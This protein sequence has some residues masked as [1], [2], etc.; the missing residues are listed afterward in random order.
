MSNELYTPKLL[1]CPSDTSHPVAR[2][3]SS[4]GPANCS[5]EYFAPVGNEKV[6]LFPDRVTV[7]CPI[8]GNIALADG[9]VQREA[10]KNHP[11]WIVERDGKLFFKAP[12]SKR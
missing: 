4:F 5:Y 8:H 9:S 2:D 12:G 10:M 11:D 7:R 6:L 3:F 1:V